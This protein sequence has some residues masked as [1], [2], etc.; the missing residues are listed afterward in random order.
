[1]DIW[2]W[3]PYTVVLAPLTVIGYYIWR[4]MFS[5]EAKI[6]ALGYGDEVEGLPPE[7]WESETLQWHYN[8]GRKAAKRDRKERKDREA[9][10]R[11]RHRLNR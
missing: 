4:A 7:Q 8:N 11:D 3:A 5:T 2:D 9:M 10:K 6:Y 1:M